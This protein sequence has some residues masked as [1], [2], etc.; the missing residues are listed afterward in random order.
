MVDTA[1]QSVGRRCQRHWGA[2]VLAVLGAACTTVP[3]VIREPIAGPE[4]A[5]VRA[6]PGRFVGQAVRWGGTVV[7]VENRPDETDVE[8]VSRPLQR[9]GRPVQTDATSGRF[10]A[11]FKGF[12]E[13]TV[14]ERG[15]E[16]TVVGAIAGSRDGLIGDYPYRFPVVRANALHL[17]EELPPYDPYPYW[18]YWDPFY[19]PWHYPYHPYW[20]R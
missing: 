15:R 14:Y 20:R 11:V 4:P 16:V 13:P 6:D 2:V 18:P 3:A 9:N 7:A 5:Q 12:L 8:I 1:F 10:L 17:W 19:Y